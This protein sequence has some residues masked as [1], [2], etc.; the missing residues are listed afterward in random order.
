[1]RTAQTVV[2]RRVAERTT[3][4]RRG[5]ARGDRIPDSQAGQVRSSGEVEHQGVVLL[6]VTADPAGI[7]NVPAVPRGRAA[8]NNLAVPKNSDTDRESD[9]PN[10]SDR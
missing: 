9:T 7:P 4:Q 2:E 10:Y 8:P 3:G 5:E 1:M 6:G